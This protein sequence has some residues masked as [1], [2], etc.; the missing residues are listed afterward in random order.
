[1]KVHRSR[2]NVTN[3]VRKHV[4]AS[5]MTN[6]GSFPERIHPFI[7]ISPRELHHVHEKCVFQTSL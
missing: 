1:M 6:L 5:E 4:I 7:E 3:K 2:N